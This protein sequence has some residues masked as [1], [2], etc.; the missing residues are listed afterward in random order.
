MLY[1]VILD[2]VISFV[3]VRV[4]AKVKY[5]IYYVNIAM[6]DV[7]T[8][9]TDLEKLTV[10]RLVFCKKPWWYFQVQ[11]VVVSTNHLLKQIMQKSDLS[12]RPVKWSFVLSKFDIQYK[13][14]TAIKGKSLAD[15]VTEF[16]IAGAC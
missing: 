8:K 3:L 10:A 14:R 6:L 2:T 12:K 7:K 5:H 1:L 13:P 9:Y 4:K 11:T 16:T 15:F